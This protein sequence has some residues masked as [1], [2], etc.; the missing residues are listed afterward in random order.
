MLLAYPFLFFSFLFLLEETDRAERERTR[1]V[2][3]RPATCSRAREVRRPELEAVR[4]EQC[5]CDARVASGLGVRI[6]RPGR[7]AGAV[8]VGSGPS[9]RGDRTD[10]ES[11][12]AVGPRGTGGARRDVEAVGALTFFEMVSNRTRG[13]RLTYQ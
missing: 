2:E 6:Y 1:S 4:C 5:D 13:G 10:Q 7:G 3:R 9:A 12:P 8:Q 11:D